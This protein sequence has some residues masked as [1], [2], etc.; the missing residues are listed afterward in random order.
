MALK[1]STTSF[2]KIFKNFNEN[3]SISKNEVAALFGELYKKY[4][5]LEKKICPQNKKG[6]LG[7]F[8]S[9]AA[10]KLA[11]NNNLG[12]NDITGS[13]NNGKIVTKDVKDK[14]KELGLEDK[15]NICKGVLKKSGNPC[16]RNGV[17]K[18][19][20]GEWYCHQHIEEYKNMK[21]NEAIPDESDIES[22]ADGDIIVSES[23][24]ESV[25]DG[26]VI[27]NES[28]SEDSYSEDEY[29]SDD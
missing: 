28:D 14:L 9:P 2:D 24:S 6:S 3:D 15:K 18:S 1:T 13:G 7:K 16:K 22:I 29:N 21:E 25:Y 27:V 10:K 4:T 20:S 19:E 5:D 23:D 26:D 8:A 12:E 17:E 11:E